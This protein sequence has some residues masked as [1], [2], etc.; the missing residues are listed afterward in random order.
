[1]H[2]AQS[3]VNVLYWATSK[4]EVREVSFGLAGK[5]TPLLDTTTAI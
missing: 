3:C 1:M 5:V 2:Y 4:R